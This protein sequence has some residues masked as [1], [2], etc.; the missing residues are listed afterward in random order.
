MSQGVNRD[1][2]AAM[3]L[4]LQEDPMYNLN[5]LH[6]LIS[7]VKPGNKNCATVIGESSLIISIFEEK[8]FDELWVF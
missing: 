2:V 1:K 5:A 7:F 3:L 8:I 6:K 4:A